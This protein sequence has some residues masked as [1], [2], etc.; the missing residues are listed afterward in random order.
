[1]PKPKL[2]L[3]VPTSEAT[4]EED[5]GTL[6][7]AKPKT[8][9]E[10]ISSGDA[11]LDCVLGGGWPLCR[12]VN[13][14]GDR[15]T[16]KTLLAIEALANFARQYPKG[17]RAYCE[18]EAAFDD[19]YAEALGLDLSDIERPEVSTVEDL[20]EALDTFIKGCTNRPGL[21]VVDSLDALSD[22]AEQGRSISDS[23]Y[24]AS[25]PKQLGALFRR[26]IKPLEKSRVCVIIISQVRDNIGVSFG[27]KHTRS[28]GKALDFYASI[29]LWLAHLEQNKL[30]RNKITRAVGVTVKAKTSKNKVGLPFRECQFQI[31]FGYGIDDIS[32]GID[33]LSAA[34]ELG[35]LG[36]N[37]TP[38]AAAAFK[39]AFTSAPTEEQREMRKALREAV[40]NVWY[41]VESTF[42][43]KKGK[44]V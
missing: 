35:R 21:F 40:T 15:S 42:A 10:F 38:Q 22:K 3:R 18:A 4:Q 19:P 2:R 36:L 37:N 13:V 20:F 5:E 17:R 33:F 8:D 16:G 28:G 31:L 12:V 29:I 1:M 43:P 30:T 44:Y 34:G 27:A 6:Y 23:T 39:K 7:F 11:V 14:V 25:K 9:L 32:S 41:A 26:L 24:G